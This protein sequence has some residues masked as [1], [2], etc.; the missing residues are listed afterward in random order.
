MASSSLFW[1]L[2]AV[3]GLGVLAS[4]LINHYARIGQQ[5]VADMDLYQILVLD[6]VNSAMVYMLATKWFVGVNVRSSRHLSSVKYF[7]ILDS[8]T[9]KYILMF[10]LAGMLLN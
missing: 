9:F 7:H 5:C 8:K 10:C 6:V 4:V 1:G 3:V 2:L